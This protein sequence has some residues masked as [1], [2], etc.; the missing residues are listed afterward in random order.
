MK[1]V[2]ESSELS[3]QGRHSEALR[4]IDRAIAGASQGNRALW[5]KVLNR[6]A[7]AISRAMGDFSLTS[8]YAG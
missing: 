5:T 7:A 2:A 4:L 3:T 6:H 8:H 1:I